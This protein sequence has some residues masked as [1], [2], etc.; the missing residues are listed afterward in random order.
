MLVDIG[1]DNPDSECIV[2]SATLFMNNGTDHS[3][4][5]DGVVMG[6]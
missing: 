5:Y 6:C 4:P 2:G 3:G 1:Q